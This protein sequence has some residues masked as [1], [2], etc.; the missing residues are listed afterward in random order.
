MFWASNIQVFI[1]SGDGFLKMKN[2]RRT[3]VKKKGVYFWRFF[4][5]ILFPAI[6]SF[7]TDDMGNTV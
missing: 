3:Q 4:E 5:T 1:I 6:F 7:F 2:Q